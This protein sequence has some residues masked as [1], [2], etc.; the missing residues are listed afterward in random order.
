MMKA[1]SEFLMSSP[2]GDESTNGAAAISPSSMK[3]K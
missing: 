2:R 1:L 3:K